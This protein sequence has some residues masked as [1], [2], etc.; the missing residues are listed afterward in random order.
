MNTKTK[1]SASLR[2][3]IALRQFLSC[4]AGKG[5]GIGNM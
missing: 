2:L 3:L 4:A 5:V 1:K